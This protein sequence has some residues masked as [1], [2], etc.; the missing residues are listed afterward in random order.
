MND[1][2]TL[3]AFYTLLS[4]DEAIWEMFRE[5]PREVMRE[6]NLPENLQELLLD[7]E[8]EDVLQVLEPENPDE[9]RA[10]LIW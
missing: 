1:R 4:K 7:G 3:I 9:V 10:F 8:V 5:N 6:Q 2:E